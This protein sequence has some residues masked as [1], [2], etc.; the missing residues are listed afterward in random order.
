MSS[1][2]FDAESPSLWLSGPKVGQVVSKNRMLFWPLVNVRF[3]II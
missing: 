1:L 2:K 3:N